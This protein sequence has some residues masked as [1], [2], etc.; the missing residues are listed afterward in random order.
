MSTTSTTGLRVSVATWAVEAKPR[1]RP[2]VEQAHHALDHGDVGGTGAAPCSSSGAIRSLADT[3]AGRG[4]G[5]G[6]RWPGRGSRGRCSRARPC[7]RHDV[8]GRRSAAIRPVATVVLPCPEAGAATTSRGRAHHSMP[9][10]PFWPASNGCLTLVISVTRSATSISFGSARRPVIDDV[11]RPGPVREGLDHVVDVDPAPV[12]RV[13]ELVEHVEVVGLVGEPA[14]DLR[15]ALGGRRGV[16][17]GLAGL[18]RPGPAGAHLVPLDRAALAGVVVQRRRA[19]EGGLLADPP[20]GRLH[21][22]EDPDRPA[23]VPAAQRE[24]ERGRRLPLAVAGVDDQQRPVAALP[25]GQ[26]VV[27]DDERLSLRHQAA[28]PCTASARG[29]PAL[30]LA[31]PARARRRGAR[32]ARR[33]ARA[34][35]GPVSQ[36]TTRRRHPPRP[37]ARPPGASGRPRRVRR[38][39]GRR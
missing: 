19:F 31:A 32:R 13:G 24:P 18:A 25:G 8:T 33:P 35:T 29:Q 28:R 7:A 3:G 10:W 4:C 5:R 6:G 17:L 12:H 14:L 26:P 37:A 36:S 2:A 1:R 22:L 23:L 38:S 11:L 20:L 30:D 15:P 21:E 34:G 27:G 9:R 16:V 39:P